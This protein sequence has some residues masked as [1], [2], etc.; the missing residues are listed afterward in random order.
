M[1]ALDIVVLVILAYMTIRG[2]MRGFVDTVFS[3]LAWVLAFK[4]GQWGTLG[5]APLFGIDN[6]GLRYFVSFA[7]VFIVVLVAVLLIGHLLGA[8]LRSLGLGAVDGVFGGLAGM[9]KAVVVLLG[10]TLAAGLTALPQTELWRNAALTG[11]FEGL[12]RHAL[13]WLPAELAEHIHY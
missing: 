11:P 4:I 9:L 1:N 5:L 3:L 7:V 6:P 10:F 12:A 2:L 13:A 8:T